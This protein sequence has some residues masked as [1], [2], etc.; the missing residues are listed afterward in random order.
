M[1]LREQPSLA[2]LAD[3]LH[4]TELG[5]GVA[6]VS[7]PTTTKANY[8]RTRQST[9]AE[10]FSE[11]VGDRVRVEVRM[12]QSG[13]AAKAS[14]RTPSSVAHADAVKDPL[15]RRAMELFDAR[16]VDVR[17]DAPSGA[18]ASGSNGDTAND[19]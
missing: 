8:A 4:L 17:D 3:D 10:I 2:S 1:K 5:A 18:A 6:I 11:V 19:E 9:L 14:T 15:V 12:A 7:A 16:I 13:A